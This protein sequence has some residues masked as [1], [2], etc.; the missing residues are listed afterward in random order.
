VT[1]PSSGG[2]GTRKMASRISTKENI[3]KKAEEDT[4]KEYCRTESDEAYLLICKNQEEYDKQL[5]TLSTGI[6]AILF[7]FLKDLVHLDS[8]IYRPLLYVGLTSLALTIAVVIL[9]YQLSNI[10]LEQV[11]SH[12]R[13]HYNGDYEHPFPEFI[14][15]FVK[16]INWG[17]G[18][19]FVVGISLAVAF[20]V[21]NLSNQS[22]KQEKSMTRVDLQEGSPL[23]TPTIVKSEERGSPTKAPIQSTPKATTQQQNPSKK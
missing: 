13:K 21:V 11:R 1:K 20:I 7:A 22:R 9:S 4:Y 19:L 18:A 23:K 16:Y 14:G 17:A 3:A 5:L 12:W 15:K 10:A 2:S 6:L 8:S